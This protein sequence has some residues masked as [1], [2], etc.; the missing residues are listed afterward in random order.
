MGFG[1]TLGSIAGGLGSMLMPI[2]GVN[3]AQLGSALGGMLGFRRGGKV[4]K[5]KAKAKK[6]KAKGKKKGNKK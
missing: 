5:A 4:R 2:P 3:G 1:S 6:A